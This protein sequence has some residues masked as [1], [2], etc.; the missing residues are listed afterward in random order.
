[1]PEIAFSR[2]TNF[3][4]SR[5]SPNRGAAFGGTFNRTPF[6]K[7]L[8]PTPG[9]VYLSDHKTIQNCKLEQLIPSSLKNY[10]AKWPRCVLSLLIYR[11]REQDWNG[12][13][14]GNREIKVRRATYG[15]WEVLTSERPNTWHSGRVAMN[16]ISQYKKYHSTLVHPKCCIS[17][18]FYFLLG[19]LLVSRE[20]GNNAYAKY[21]RDKQSWG[22]FDIG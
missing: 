8:D 21:W 18:V 6:C 4:I 16:T 12:G 19:L 1:M 3:N 15:K 7:N 14:G 13:G 17:I 10:V 9:N 5:G 20:T 22:I 11:G 2:T